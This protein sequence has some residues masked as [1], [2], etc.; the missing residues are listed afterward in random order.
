[1]FLG[2][3]PQ[4]CLNNSACVHSQFWGCASVFCSLSLNCLSVKLPLCIRCSATDWYILVPQLWMQKFISPLLRTTM[5]AE[6]HF[7]SAENPVLWKAAYRVL[8]KYSL[9]AV[10]NSV[11]VSA[12]PFCLL[13]S[14]PLQAFVTIKITHWELEFKHQVSILHNVVSDVKVAES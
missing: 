3:V 12:V 9:L 5:D 14:F 11:H 1:M 10:G 2:E 8:S 13:P 6:I 7:P 4:I